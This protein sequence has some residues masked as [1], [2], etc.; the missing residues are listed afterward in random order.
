MKQ[1]YWAG[2][3]STLVKEYDILTFWGKL[4]VLDVFIGLV[5]GLILVEPVMLV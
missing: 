4:T 3:L 1:Q 5:S 2:L